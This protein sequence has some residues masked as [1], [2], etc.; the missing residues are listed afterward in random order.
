MK[1]L[2]GVI[3]LFG[4]IA[5]CESI[6]PYEKEYLVNPLM[7]D[8]ALNTLKSDFPL[9]TASNFERLGSTQGGGGATSCPTCGG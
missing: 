1:M 8:A 2:I 9:T 7:D 3:L 5:G 6:K 4:F